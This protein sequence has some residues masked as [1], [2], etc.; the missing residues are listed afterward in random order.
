MELTM[1]ERNA[2]ELITQLEKKHPRMIVG[3]GTV[4][5]LDTARARLRRAKFISTPGLDA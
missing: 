5:D 1:S 4:L 3:A 2:T